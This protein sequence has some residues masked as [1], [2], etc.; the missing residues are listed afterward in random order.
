MKYQADYAIE[1]Q[2]VNKTYKNGIQALKGLNMKVKAGEI[3]SLL[4]ENGAGKSTLIRILTAFLKPSAGKIRV[5]GKDICADSVY[6]RSNFACVSQQITIDT[7]LSLQENMMFQAGLYKVPKKEAKNRMKKLIKQFNL[8][9]YANYPVASYS[10]GIKRRLD[11]AVNMMSNPEILFLDEPTVGMDIQSRKVMWEMIRKI[12]DESGTTVFLTT[13]Y[14]EEADELSDTICIMRNGREV[15][16]GSPFELK[17]YLRQDNVKITLSSK[18][19]TVRL[20]ERLRKEYGKENIKSENTAVIISA[21]NVMDTFHS[22]ATYLSDSQI[23][24]CGIEIVQPTLEDVFLRLTK[25]E[26]TV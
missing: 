18:D 8:E 4:G 10:G 22:L 1:T 9:P 2:D 19:Y 7:H 13:H 5:L 24:F 6:I 3:Y 17:K 20:K 21:E 25:K 15:I 23:P 11:I 14:L 26:N 16:Q 12:R